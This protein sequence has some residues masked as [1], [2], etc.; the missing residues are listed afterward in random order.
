MLTVFV[1]GVITLAACEPAKQ[2][3]VPDRHD[4]ARVVEPEAATAVA[5][6]P[7]IASQVPGPRWE[8]LVQRN[9]DPAVSLPETLISN[10]IAAWRRLPAGE[11][12]ARWARLFASRT[13]NVYCFGPKPGGYTAESLLVQDFKHDCVSLYYR[14]T[15]LARAASARDALRLA[16]GT[17]FA[18]VNPSAWPAP[19]GAMNYDDPAHLDYSEDMIRTGLWGADVTKEVG[20]AIPDAAGTSRYAA[21]TYD[22]IPKSKLRYGKLRS[23]D[24][25]YFVL[26]EA[27]EKART[28]REKYGLL[29]GHQGIVDRDGDTVYVIHAAQSDLPGIY[30]GNRVVRVPLRTYLD[31]VE[32]F[33]GVMISRLEEP[34][35][36]RP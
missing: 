36:P 9:L 27:N 22:F 25:L 32:R 30:A 34:A 16:Y 35:Q 6:T 11:R 29:V 19:T 28:L 15:E 12:V 1:H 24:L 26:D 7:G 4:P 2:V 10:R 8:R 14:T 23:G 3:Q 5:T 13:D 18:D 31:R 33:K 17:R 21:G 20:V